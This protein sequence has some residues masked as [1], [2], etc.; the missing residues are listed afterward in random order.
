MS[1]RPDDLTPPTAG[2]H[3]PDALRDDPADTL[4]PGNP[5]PIAERLW[6]V[7]LQALA[8]R[9]WQY[10]G[11]AEHSLVSRVRGEAANY[12]VILTVHEDLDVLRCW[13]VFPVYVGEPWRAAACDLLNRINHDELLMGCFEMAPDAGRVRWRLGCDVEGGVLSTQMVHNILTAGLAMSD[14]FFPALM[15]V[16]VLGL[17]PEAALA[18]VEG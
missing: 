5:A 16:G 4:E 14:R 11:L 8:E 12:D 6:P 17:S 9:E 7:V 2:D 1:D 13:V 18:L 15:A 3:D 10:D